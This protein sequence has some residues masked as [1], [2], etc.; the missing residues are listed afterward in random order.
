M[1]LLDLFIS[2]FK[3]GLLSFGGGYAMITMLCNEAVSHNWM[4]TK[5]FFDIVAI[6][7]I[8]PGPI[9]VNMS[10]FVGF[11]KFGILGAISATLGVTLPSFILVLVLLHF[12]NKFSDSSFVKNLFYGLKPAVAALI[13]TAII[14]IG[15]AVYLPNTNFFDFS[16]ITKI[17]IMPIVISIISFIALYKFKL[18][19]IAAI[20]IFAL[21]GIIIM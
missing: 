7:Q 11:K 21:I 1:I 16:Q 6:S 2:F 18:D 15:W 3:T 13:V 20:L 14:Q 12:I 17:R 10:T 19:T 4:S 5:E 9:A 8:T